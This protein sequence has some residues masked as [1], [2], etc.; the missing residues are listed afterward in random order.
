MAIRPSVV[1]TLSPAPSVGD[2]WK[3]AVLPFRAFGLLFRSPR[4][5]GLAAISS[6]VTLVALVA[7]AFLLFTYA[8]GW[9]TGLWP[10]PEAWYA[11]ALWYLVFVGGFILFLVV[12]AN[13]VPLLLTAP[14]QDT[15]SE[16]TEAMCGDFRSEPL[17]M[18]SLL[19]G[20]RT[21]LSH[22]ARRIAVLWLGHL[23]LFVLHFLPGVGSVLWSVLSVLWTVWWLTGEYLGGPM[24]RRLYPF[25]EV[26][27][28]MRK[29]PAAA[30]GFGMAVYL[31]LWVPLLNLFLIPLATV[32]GT[33]FFRALRASNDLQPP[34][35][36][37]LKR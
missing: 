24:A 6:V 19:R 11:L 2:L 12:G 33:L 30:L 4:L 32:G 9:M 34:P 23:L 3:G 26:R 36:E 20:L 17:S 16:A 35:A 15:M 1:P 14:L 25:S 10:R 13:T 31:L 8:E 27:T 7:W 29:R 37:R 28:A 21:S 22:T 5:L 18:K